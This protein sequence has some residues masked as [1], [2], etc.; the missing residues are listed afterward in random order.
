M[1][2]YKCNKCMHEFLKKSHYDAHLERKNSC[3]IDVNIIKCEYCDY[4]CGRESVLKKHKR[5]RCKIRKDI[6]ED[7]SREIGKEDRL[8]SLEEQLVL[9]RA[10]LTTQQSN[11]NFNN[12]NCNNTNI[13]N[14]ISNQFM[15]VSFGKEDIDKLSKKEKR[16]ILSSS[17]AAI[18]NCVKKMNF[19]PNIPEQNNI[20]ITNPK[21]E[22]A[23]KFENGAFIA[24]TT[25]DLLEELIQNRMNDVRELV[26][27]NDELKVPEVKIERVN[28]LLTNIEEEKQE[29]LAN[30]KKDIKLTMFNENKL[31]LENKKMIEHKN[32]RKK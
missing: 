5:Y 13:T 11:S 6:E 16:E 8:K 12:T 7:E 25:N 21:S 29:D 24:V 10:L 20:F 19:N 31:A 4:E 3:M 26:E 32:K 1:V 15:I 9:L 22:F 23:Y 18:I 14:N 30:L 28:N 17:Y 2:V 27:Q